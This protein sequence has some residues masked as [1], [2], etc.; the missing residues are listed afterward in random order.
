VSKSA[1]AIRHVAFED[2]G[3]LE[4]LLRDRGFDVSY[5][6]AGT[7]D[8]G[9]VDP[10]TPDLVV[11][12]GGPIGVYE[13]DSYPWIED[14]VALLQQ[15]LR[16][17]RPTLGICLGCQMMARALGAKVYP[18]PVTEL[19]WAPIR[20][21]EAGRASPLRHIDGASV[22][23]WHGDT[24]D[25]P[26]GVA[27]LASTQAVENQAFLV[28]DHGLALQ[29]HVE[30]TARSLERWFIAHAVEISVTEGVSVPALRADTERHGPVLERLGRE[31]LSEWLDR[32]GD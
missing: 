18:G 11:A 1:L 20:L 21:T 24:F 25:L 19:G 10:L 8:L 23:H 3:I 22:L 31:L 9:A 2:L 6:E 14:E 12:L 16:A 32:A 5:R 26:E 30:V 7:D 13:D 4:P 29:F 28:G 15:R 27:L 17:A